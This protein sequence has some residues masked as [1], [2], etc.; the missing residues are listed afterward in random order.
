MSSVGDRLNTSRFR[1]S[2][3]GNSMSDSPPLVPTLPESF[4]G[5]RLELDPERQRADVILD[6]PTTQHPYDGR[7]RAI[8]RRVRSARRRYPHPHRPDAGRGVRFVIDLAS[9]AL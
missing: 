7:A 5:F 8:A 2:T 4:D 3:G 6:R 1:S 9:P